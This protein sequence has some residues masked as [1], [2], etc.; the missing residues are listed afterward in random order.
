M[1]LIP[2]IP[3]SKCALCADYSDEE[4][5]TA[6]PVVCPRE[7]RRPGAGGAEYGANTHTHRERL[8]GSRVSSERVTSR[9]RHDP[10]PCL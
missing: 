7:S 10:P 6:S 4:R 1:L 9:T 8:Y 2:S 3:T 5:R